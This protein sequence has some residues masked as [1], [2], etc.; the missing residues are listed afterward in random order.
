MYWAYPVLVVQWWKWAGTGRYG[1]P[2]G[3]IIVPPGQAREPAGAPREP[4]GHLEYQYGQYLLHAWYRIKLFQTQAQS[5]MLA[6]VI[7]HHKHISR[8]SWRSCM[9]CSVSLE[10]RRT[11]DKCAAQVAAQEWQSSRCV[12]A[13]FKQQDCEESLGMLCSSASSLRAIRGRF[14]RFKRAC[15]VPGHGR[16]IRVGCFPQDCCCGVWPIGGVDLTVWEPCQCPKHSSGEIIK[17]VRKQI[18]IAP[19]FSP[20]IQRHWKWLSF[21]L[22]RLTTVTR[23]AKLPI[24]RLFVTG[25]FDGVI[26]SAGY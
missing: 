4:A 9:G 13:C 3:A 16:Q 2:A 23:S 7:T 18:C 17:E 11:L 5:I 10:N 21:K 26:L 25:K 15:T 14:K 24:L 22:E 8:Y 1:V 6:Y 19:A 20:K 12:M